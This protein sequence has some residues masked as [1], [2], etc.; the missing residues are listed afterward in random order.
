MLA[1]GGVAFITAAVAAAENDHIYLYMSC[2]DVRDE[3]EQGGFRVLHENSLE[4][5]FGPEFM[6]FIDDS[7]FESL[8]CT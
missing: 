4:L 5:G 7:P 3:L 8:L 6:V 2:K 1:P